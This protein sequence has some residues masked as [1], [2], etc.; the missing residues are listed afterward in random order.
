MRDASKCNKCRK[1]RKACKFDGRSFAKWKLL[2]DES[3]PGEQ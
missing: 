1:D 3:S 2:H